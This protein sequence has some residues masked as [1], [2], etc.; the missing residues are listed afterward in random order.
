MQE[1]LRLEETFYLNYDGCCDDDFTY[2]DADFTPKQGDVHVLVECP[3]EP[4]QVSNYKRKIMLDQD[5]FVVDNWFSWHSPWTSL[6]SL[7]PR[8]KGT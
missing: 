5:E 7:F 3:D 8:E 2:F 1:H 4:Y 6:Q